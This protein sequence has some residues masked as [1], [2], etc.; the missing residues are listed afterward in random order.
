MFLRHVLVGSSLGE[1]RSFFF[2]M[3]D[4]QSC[5]ARPFIFVLKFRPMH[6]MYVIRMLPVCY[7]CGVLIMI[8]DFTYSTLTRV[9]PTG[10]T[11]VRLLN[12]FSDTTH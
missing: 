5:S 12:I 3:R 11:I 4:E 10:Q 2:L 6:D 7:S 1:S 9:L 8:L